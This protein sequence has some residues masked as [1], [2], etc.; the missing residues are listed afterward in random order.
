MFC[1]NNKYILT[2]FKKINIFQSFITSTTL[3]FFNGL[4]LIRSQRSLLWKR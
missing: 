2:M 4:I 3:N 1:F